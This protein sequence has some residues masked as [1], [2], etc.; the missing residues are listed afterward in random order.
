MGSCEFTK[1]RHGTILGQQRCIEA[2]C[3]NSKSSRTSTKTAFPWENPS[4]LSGCFEKRHPRIASALFLGMSRMRG[5]VTGQ[6]TR[7]ANKIAKFLKSCQV[8]ACGLSGNFLSP[9]WPAACLAVPATVR[10][11]NRINAVDSM[12]DPKLARAGETGVL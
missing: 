7:S 10:C 9:L 1:G 3:Y 8:I 4:L 5:R 6:E 2:Q 12:S 11:P